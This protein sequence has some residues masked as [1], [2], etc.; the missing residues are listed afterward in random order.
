MATY[1]MGVRLAL[2]VAAAKMIFLL[3]VNT[4]NVP[5]IKMQ[6]QM[7]KV[8]EIRVLKAMFITYGPYLQ[9][10]SD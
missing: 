6:S 4:K 5:I 7:I 9:A 2:I 8:I 10:C 3:N 1:V